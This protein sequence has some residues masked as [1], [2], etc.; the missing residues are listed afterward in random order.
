M[1][2]N[3]YRVTNRGG[4]GVRTLNVTEK[5]GELVAMQSVN[6]EN[7]LVII[8]KSGI[9]LRIHVAD[10]RVQGR[11]TQG[12]RLINLDKRGDTIA[13]VCCVD[14]DPDE[15]VET[16]EEQAPVPDTPDTGVDEPDLT[17]EEIEAIDEANSRVED[18][19]ATLTME[20]EHPGM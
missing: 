11:N 8:N 15:A 9:T 17:P 6:D 4:K 16:L 3:V 12:V 5:T 13:S 10:I 14:S 7:D 20:E 2:E 18:Q 19:Q 1:R